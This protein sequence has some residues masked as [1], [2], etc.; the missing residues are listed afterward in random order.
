LQARKQLVN[1]SGDIAPRGGTPGSHV[2][3]IGSQGV[4][5]ARHAGDISPL[6]GSKSTPS[7]NC[8][9]RVENH[10]PACRQTTE[11][12]MPRMTTKE[13]KAPQGLPGTWGWHETMATE[14]GTPYPDSDRPGTTSDPRLHQHAHHQQLA[15]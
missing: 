13:A 2:S 3:N 12:N 6:E 15:W 4:K 14:Q 8:P 7:G 5:N 10:V 9:Q 11:A 1:D